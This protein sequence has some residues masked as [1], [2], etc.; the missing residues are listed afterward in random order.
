MFCSE[1]SIENQELCPVALQRDISGE[2]YNWGPS[3]ILSLP[4]WRATHLSKVCFT[5]FH[6]EF[7]C[8]KCC[9]QN[10]ISRSLIYNAHIEP[11]PMVWD[12]PSLLVCYCFFNH[13]GVLSVQKESLWQLIGTQW[14]FFKFNLFVN[15]Q[16][17][18]HMG[19]NM[20]V[21]AS[22]NERKRCMFTA[23][24]FSVRWLQWVY[25]LEHLVASWW[26]YFGRC[27]A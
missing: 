20:S 11:G 19:V 9:N 21:Y 3:R 1:D 12:Q 18:D 15:S 17:H 24:G 25:M 8:W 13:E 4:Q 7:Y 5:R 23:C 14:V 16:S 10:R 27:K 22:E 2:V 6:H 26:W